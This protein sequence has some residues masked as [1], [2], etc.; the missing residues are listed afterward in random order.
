MNIG[1]SEEER[2][3]MLEY[4]HTHTIDEVGDALVYIHIYRYI[5]DE[6]GDGGHPLLHLLY[7][8]ITASPLYNII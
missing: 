4:T 5:I 3:A 7:I 1:F 6:V 2:E 8:Y